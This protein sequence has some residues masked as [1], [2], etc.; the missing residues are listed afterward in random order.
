MLENIRDK[1]LVPAD[2][3]DRLIPTRVFNIDEYITFLYKNKTEIEKQIRD[4]EL[5]RN[6]MLVRAKEL[7]IVTDPEYK[8]VEVPI[9]AKKKVNVELLKKLEPDRYV[10]IITNICSRL[11][12]KLRAEQDKVETFISQADVKA[13]IIDKG[14]LAQIIPEPS[15]PIGFETAVVKR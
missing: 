11:S 13:V 3:N 15:E 4:A 1:E 2:E 7:N 6:T 14:L 12:D 10:Q 9:Y 5:D 8:I